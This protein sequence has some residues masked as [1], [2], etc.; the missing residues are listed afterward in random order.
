M[1]DRSGTRSSKL[2]ERA[3]EFGE[4]IKT[5]PFLADAGNAPSRGTMYYV[6]PSAPIFYAAQGRSFWNRMRLVN[7]G[8][9][10]GLMTGVRV[11]AK[12]ILRRFF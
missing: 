1:L 9:L 5:A 3:L 8:D 12:K 2:R 4:D 7:L 10:W 6:C 11:A